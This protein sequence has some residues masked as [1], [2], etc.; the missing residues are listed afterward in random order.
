[1]TPPVHR[2]AAAPTGLLEKLLGAV[3]PEFRVD[4]YVPAPT[5]RCW[6]A[7]RAVQRVVTGPAGSTG[8]APPTATDGARRA[9]P[10]LPASVPSRVRNG[11]ADARC[12]GAPL[13]M[14][15]RQQR[16]RVVHAAPQHL[17]LLES[18]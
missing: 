17:D 1:M 3:R 12:P 13:R 8:S 16:F 2:P 11:T 15:L 7:H 18:A 5:I 9:A 14:P 6:D 10:T 4:V